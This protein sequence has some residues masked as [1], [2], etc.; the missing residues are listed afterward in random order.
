MYYLCYINKSED[1]LHGYCAADLCLCFH[2]HAKSRFSHDAAHLQLLKSIQSVTAVKLYSLNSKKKQ[3]RIHILFQFQCILCTKNKLGITHLIFF[4][5]VLSRD[6]LVSFLVYAYEKRRRTP[7]NCM[8]HCTR[9]FINN[10]LVAS[11]GC[12]SLRVTI[13]CRYYSGSLRSK[14]ILANTPRLRLSLRFGPFSKQCS[15]KPL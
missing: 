2:M 11:L 7:K 15:S 13:V 3:S 4:H 1:L 6:D 5:S 9:G 12:T 14:N 8:L 10:K